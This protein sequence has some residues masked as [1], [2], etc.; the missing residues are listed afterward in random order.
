MWSASCLLDWL[1][2]GSN[3]FWVLLFLAYLLY[4][5]FLKYFNIILNLKSIGALIC[6]GGSGEPFQR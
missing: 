6:C 3:K 5:D 2:C 1:N 4:V